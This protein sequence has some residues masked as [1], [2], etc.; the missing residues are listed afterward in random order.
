MNKEMKSHVVFKEKSV[1]CI[2]VNHSEQVKEMNFKR[3]GARLDKEFGFHYIKWKTNENILLRSSEIF[4]FV[5]NNNHSGCGMY[6]IYGQTDK[7][8]Q[9]LK[10]PISQPRLGFAVITENSRISAI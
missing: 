4:L 8:G 9:Q 5:F 1:N 3:A 10:G 6:V 2:R 7:P